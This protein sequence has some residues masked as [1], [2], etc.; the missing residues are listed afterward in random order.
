MHDDRRL[1]EERLDRFVNGFLN[2]AVYG[3]SAPVEVT[4]W[5]VPGE[6]VPFAEAV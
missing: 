5:P 4:A 6:P 2:G 1:T 3:D